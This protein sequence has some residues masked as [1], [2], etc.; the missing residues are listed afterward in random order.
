MN[1]I[2]KFKNIGFWTTS[3]II[4][5]VFIAST[6]VTYVETFQADSEGIV[7][8]TII[9]SITNASNTGGFMLLPDGRLYISAYG[10]QG[11][12][13]SLF[14]LGD[15]FDVYFKVLKY[16][17]GF[18]FA[19]T[20]SLFLQSIKRE[21]GKITFFVTLIGIITSPWLILF[22]LNL[23]WVIFL[24]FLPFVITWR[25]YNEI[26][27]RYYCFFIVFLFF[28]KSLCGYEYI[29]NIS[30]SCLIPIIYYELNKETH[31][32]E[33]LK[34]CAITF[35]STIFGFILAL[36]LHLVQGYNHFG[37]LQEA[38]KV[39]SQ[40]GTARSFGDTL[41]KE[42]SF[43]NDF[44]TLLKYFKLPASFTAVS[45]FTLFV[46]FMLIII[47]FFI[48]K[49]KFV[50]E[51]K[52]VNLV[53]VCFIS[54]IATFSWVVIAQGHMRYHLHINSI[55]FYIPFNLMLFVT[56]GFI[57]SRLRDIINHYYLK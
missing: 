16:T 30:L 9:N 51:S 21:F 10:I 33:I 2:A 1:I 25:Y 6:A 36:G 42:I 48:N 40:R 23:Y 44:I 27:F 8:T 26:K 19:A 12:I 43:F 56:I 46:V 28:I 57:F 13:F 32:K 11:K 3:L 38:I 54:L 53:I 29:T 55:I 50:K 15:N 31:F 37:S 7:T 35:V 41:G 52:L 24:S 47:Y 18:M 14:A 34:K 4:F 17:V 22:S 20:L 45:Q 5:F 49:S 39:I